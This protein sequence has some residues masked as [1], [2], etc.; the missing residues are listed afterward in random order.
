MADDDGG[1][2][3]DARLEELAAGWA[4]GALAPAELEELLARLRRDDGAAAAATVWRHLTTTADL[5][6]QLS[7]AMSDSVRLRLG[8]GG[9]VAEAIRRRIGPARPGLAP[10]ADGGGP[11][12]RRWGQVLTLAGF[13]LIA[14]LAWW[15]WRPAGGAAVARVVALE[16]TATLSGEALAPG[17]ALDPRSLVVPAGAR[18]ELAWP[19]GGGA[20]LLGPAMAVAQGDGLSLHAGAARCR[21]PLRLGL[22]DRVVELPAQARAAVAVRDALSSLGCAAGAF[23]VDG[24]QLAPGQASA[25]GEPFPWRTFTAEPPAGAA[26]WQAEVRISWRAG[27]SVRLELAEALALECSPGRITVLNQGRR[28]ELVLGGAPLAPLVLRLE[29]HVHRL[30]VAA[31]GQEVLDAQIAQPLVRLDAHGAEVALNGATGPLSPGDAG[32]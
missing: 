22:P 19:G 1:P 7:P 24:R 29:L 23:T 28:N 25:G 20:T 31:A 18:L 5:R 15:W 14:L 11:P 10:V 16:G 21:G 27:G 17:S 26:A 9:G 12:P 3:P 30:R 32:R 4:I 8:R 2:P 13:A 6:A